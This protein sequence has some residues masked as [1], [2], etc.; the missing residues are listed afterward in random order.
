VA[1]DETDALGTV[2]TVALEVA[3]PPGPALAGPACDPDE[4]PL[5][6]AAV[7]LAEPVPVASAALVSAVALALP[8]APPLDARAPALPPAPP[9]AFAVLLAS[10]LG[11]TPATAVASPPGPP[12]TPDVPLVPGVP[13]TVTVTACA[14]GAY[15]AAD[16]V[17]P[18]DP[19]VANTTDVF[20]AGPP[21]KTGQRSR[22]A[23]H[24]A[25]AKMGDRMMLGRK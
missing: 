17:K 15:G 22:A 4:P 9:I 3:L 13:I 5:P 20:I 18:S 16:T 10:V 11:G 23:L 12:S 24:A 21:S 19:I 25:I 8:P 1:V 7:A 2:I 14:D 6:P